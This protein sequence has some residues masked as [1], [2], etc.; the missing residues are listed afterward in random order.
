LALVALGRA[1]DRTSDRD[2]LQ[3]VKLFLFVDGGGDA[4][5][6]CQDDKD[7]FV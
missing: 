4:L 2:L 7:S 3:L 5:L 6:V 1:L